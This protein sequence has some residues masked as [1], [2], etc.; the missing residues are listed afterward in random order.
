[1][2]K[3][4][5]PA[6]FPLPGL[7]TE[8][9]AGDTMHDGRDDHYLAV[10]LSALRC[11]D[12]ALGESVPQRILDLPCG[13]GRVTRMLR[14][15]YA[16]AQITVSD[17]DRP[18]V[19]FAAAQFAARGVYSVENLA[20]LDLRETFD[21]IWVGSLVTH[22]SE[23]QTRAFLRTMHRAMAPHATLLISSHGPTI[24]EG[25]K[26]WCYGLEPRAAAA[27][28]DDYAATGYGHRGYGQSEGYGISLTDRHWWAQAAEEYGLRLVSYEERAWD[29]HQD[30][31]TLRRSDPPPNGGNA[32]RVEPAETDAILRKR[33][34]VADYDGRMAH[35]DPA[36][37]L[38]EYPDV[39]AAIAA[40]QSE[41]AYDHYRKMGLNEG[42]HP[43]PGPRQRT[44][45][46][47]HS[48]FDERWYLSAFPDVE[49]AVA[50]GTCL[51][52]YDHWLDR[53]QEEGRPPHG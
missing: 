27:I 35:F 28:M 20:E 3:L 50:R 41:S 14:A 18:G 26:Q 51:S 24:V 11:I 33:Q 46:P 5:I 52:A 30:V 10:G 23:V 9:A 19:D 40:G 49:A 15:Q 32:A 37:Y 39:A 31:L 6:T 29:G 2:A 44:S 17:L 8:L 34:K 42:R 13:F 43:Y 53:G 16:Q 47:A 22:L 12:S 1:M 7:V 25:L 4:Q 48:S 45:I 21:L 38:A 36:Y